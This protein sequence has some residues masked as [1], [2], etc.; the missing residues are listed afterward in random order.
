MC[1]SMGIRN[2]KKS[3]LISGQTNVMGIDNSENEKVTK[4]RNIGDFVFDI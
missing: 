3:Y 4:K 1:I 2:K